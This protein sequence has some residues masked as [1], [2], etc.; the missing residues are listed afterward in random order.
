MKNET[1][2]LKEQIEYCNCFIS[3]PKNKAEHKKIVKL[4]LKVF[5]ER[6]KEIS[7]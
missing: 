6:L 7:K 1:E 2:W 4:N 3:I 5:E